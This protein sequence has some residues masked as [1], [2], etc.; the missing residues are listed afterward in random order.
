ML[1]KYDKAW[2]IYVSAVLMLA[3]VFKE[4]IECQ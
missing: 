4:M 3:T 1:I 2:P